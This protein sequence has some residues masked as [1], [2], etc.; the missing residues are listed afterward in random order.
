MQNPWAYLTAAWGKPVW[1]NMRN[2][3]MEAS[4]TGTRFTFQPGT[5]TLEVQDDRASIIQRINSSQG[6]PS[7]PWLQLNGNFPHP[8]EP[9]FVNM[10]LAHYMHQ[11]ENEA[12]STHIMFSAGGEFVSETP[13]EIWAAMHGQS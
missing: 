5:I 8:A 6:D 12:G 13:P 1:V 9:V 10:T 11:P 2:A 3:R 4:G 7:H